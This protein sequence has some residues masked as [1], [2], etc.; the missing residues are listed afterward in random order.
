M[1]V[2]RE[3]DR[4]RVLRRLGPTFHWPI[5]KRRHRLTRAQPIP[6][7]APVVRGYRFVDSHNF[8]WAGLR[9]RPQTATQRRAQRGTWSAKHAPHAA[10]GVSTG[11]KTQCGN[12]SHGHASHGDAGPTPPPHR[13]QHPLRLLAVALRRRRSRP[14][15]RQ[16]AGGLPATAPAYNPAAPDPPSSYYRHHH[17]PASATSTAHNTIDT[18]HATRHSPHR[19]RTPHPHTTPAPHAHAHTRHNEN[20]ARQ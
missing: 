20:Q 18:R 10:R 5:L 19:T 17:Q 3:A 12:S 7:G 11:G 15:R 6:S 1:R 16:C 9:C 2:R 13:R 4:N 8:S 14:F